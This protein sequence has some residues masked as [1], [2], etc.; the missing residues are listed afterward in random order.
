MAVER[1]ACLIC[2][3]T[4]MANSH[5][6]PRG[7]MHDIR[8]GAPHLVGVSKGKP[9]TKF[10]QS[11]QTSRT[12][13]CHAHEKQTQAGDDYAIRFC[14]RYSS[15]AKITDD[16]LAAEISN[17][18]PRRLTMFVHATIWRHAAHFVSHGKP[19]ALGAHFDLVSDVVFRGAQPLEAFVIDP[20]RLSGGKRAQLA[21][22]PVPW[23]FAGRQMLRMEIGG[24]SFVMNLSD[25]PVA[26]PFNLMST[27]NDPMLVLKLRSGEL[28]DD[29]MIREIAAANISAEWERRQS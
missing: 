18:H 22:A 17:P 5:L 1:A 24:L 26:E 20:E 29:P 23:L 7:L 21:I 2:G 4:L 3:S 11:G 27:E 8:K 12:I 9:E 14:R 10:L 6:F 28:T 16:G 13:L 15:Q 25:E 19:S